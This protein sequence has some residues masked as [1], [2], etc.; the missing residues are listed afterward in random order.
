M[1]IGPGKYS[2]D[3]TIQPDGIA[4]TWGK[5]LIE[6]KGGL[7]AFIRFFLKEMQNEET[8]WLQRSKNKP[9]H[10]VLYVYVIV[11][12]QIKY[13]LNYVGYESGATIINNGAGDGSWS[14]RQHIEWPRILMAGPVITAPY[15][16]EQRGFQG[17]RYTVKLF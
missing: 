13:R 11:C 9:Q 7:F 8:I 2:K 12:N 5:D 17:F 3:P 15:K 6:E 4:I 16:M 14:S 1:I 10:E